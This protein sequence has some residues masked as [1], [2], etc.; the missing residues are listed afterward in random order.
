MSSFQALALG[1]AGRVGAGN[2]AGVAV[3]LPAAITA[4]LVLEGEIQASG[5]RM[6]PTLPELYKPA[7]EESA[8]FGYEFKRRTVP[9]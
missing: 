6:P 7:L 1:V 3:A 4:R 2:I 9:A 8:T 5:E